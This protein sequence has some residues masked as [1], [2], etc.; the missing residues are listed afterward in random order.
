MAWPPVEA[1]LPG[2]NEAEAAL[3]ILGDEGLVKATEN[4]AKAA[5]AILHKIQEYTYNKATEALAVRSDDT[6]EP[7]TRS[8]RR[9]AF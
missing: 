7:R 2:L 8:G 5:R 9:I 6:E 4:L 3:L 1:A